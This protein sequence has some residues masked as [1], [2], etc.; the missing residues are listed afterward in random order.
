MRNHNRLT[1]KGIYLFC[2]ILS[3]TVLIGCRA[4]IPHDDLD[5]IQRSPYKDLSTLAE[6]HIVHVPTGVEMT[7]DQ[8]IDYISHAKVIYI[9]EMHTNMKHHQIQLDLIKALEKRFPGKIT[10]GMEMFPR[11]AQASLDEWS[12]GDLDKKS[13]AKIWHT[14]WQQDL[15][16]Y[17]DIFDYIKNNNIPL[18]GLNASQEEIG[19]LSE[20][21]LEEFLKSTRWDPS[22]FDPL[23]PYQKQAM[24]AFF[25]GHGHG[26]KMFDRFYQRMLLW[27]GT[28]ARAIL[29]YFSSENGKDRKMVV[30]AGGF[31][32]NFGFGI[33]RRVFKK[34]PEPY[35]IVLPH[36]V[37]LPENRSSLL[38][39]VQFPDLPLYYADFIWATGYQDLEDKKVRLGVKIEPSERGVVVLSVSEKSVA[40]RAGLKKGDIITN[41]GGKPILEPFDLIFLVQQS[42]PGDKTTLQLVRDNETIEFSIEF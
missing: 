41:F 30:L 9:G 16:Y 12:R 1:T 10:V 14:H 11:S 13:F 18:L 31:H 42:T 26:T 2:G 36:T 40:E 27:D 25:Q 38:M 17:I 4:S 29:D 7:Q 33:P 15:N 28:M 5:S 37:S 6:E 22:E 19:L 23:D 39:N 3:V 8:L 34:L 24:E 21:G 35:A 32:V 20:M